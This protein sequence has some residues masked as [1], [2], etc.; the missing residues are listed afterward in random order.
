M[1]GKEQPSADSGSGKTPAEISEKFACV[2]EGEQQCSEPPAPLQLGCSPALA[3]GS[4]LLY[5]KPN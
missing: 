1:T 5:N 2:A 3:A 4:L